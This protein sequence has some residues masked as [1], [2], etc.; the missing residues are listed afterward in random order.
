MALFGLLPD[1]PKAPDPTKTAQTQA[2]YNKDA[3][4]TSI[5]M[6]SQNRTGP[7]GS[8]TFTKD[9][10]GNVNGMTTSLDPSLQGA[11]S[12]FTG[13]LGTTAGMLP[14]QAFS[15][16]GAAPD[17]S[18]LSKDFYNNGA[19]LMQPQMD[20]QRKQ[21]DEQLT[22]RGLPIGSEAYTDA[23]GNMQRS[24]NLALSDLASRATQLA[25]AEQQRLIN[26]ART[27]YMLPYEQA[28]GTLGLLQGLNTLAPQAQQAQANVGSPD[29]MGAVNNKY[30]ADMAAYNAKMQGIGQLAGAGAGLLLGQMPAG[31]F[32]NTVAG[33][34]YKGIF[35]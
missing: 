20:Q 18:Y 17:T 19:A 14:G 24:Q 22:N 32:G 5:N 2:Q 28:H 16:T 9:A 7:F 3:A 13:A 6:N 4:Q 11:A 27:D 34:A 10:S 21:L 1:A 8:S 23:T 31:G 35:G 33:T 15:S 25:P 12:G 26:N 30:N 29:Y